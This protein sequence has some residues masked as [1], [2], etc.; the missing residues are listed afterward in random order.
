MDDRLFVNQVVVGIVAAALTAAAW[1]N[2]IYVDDDNCPGPGDGS[3]LDPYCSIQTAI[4]NAVDTDEI[5]VAPGTY[6]SLLINFLGKAIT[7][8][9]SDGPEVTIIDANGRPTVITCDSGEG[10]DT[11]L[12][13]FTLTGGRSCSCWHHGG[14]MTNISS[15]P[16]VT[17]CIITGNPA[18]GGM[19]NLDSSPTVTNCVF[20]GND[21]GIISVSA[22]GPYDCCVPHD[23]PGCDDPDCEEIVCWLDPYCCQV[24][25]D[26]LCAEAALIYCSCGC[27]GHCGG[28][29][30]NLEGSNPTVTGCK[31]IGNDGLESGGGIQN[32]D[33]SNPTVIDCTFS[34]NAA[35][36]GGGMANWSSNPTVINC[37][38]IGNEAWLGGGISNGGSSP[39]VT[40]CTFSGN[41]ADSGGSMFNWFGA[42]PTL[43]NCIAWGNFPDQIFDDPSD[44]PS[45]ST[46]TYSNAQGGWPGIGNIDSD[47]RCVDP[48]SGDFRLSPGSP[49]I[50]AGDNTAVP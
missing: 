20:S 30:R 14:G 9:S 34:G 4:D 11:V 13:G 26:S 50:D 19:F 10:P 29:M 12:D 41:T 45:T 39:T 2:T 44:P 23:T 17:N 42:N 5:V 36:Y 7:L 46:V 35:G 18:G 40:N 24:E 25:W 3:E 15:D 38:F 27:H 43:S 48:G 6:S 28:G 32:Y 16:T 1:A 22:A 47:P 8:R 31:F 33:N 21:W 49:C 37:T